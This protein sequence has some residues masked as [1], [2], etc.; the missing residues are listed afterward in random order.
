MYSPCQGL[1]GILPVYSLLEFVLILHPICFFQKVKDIAERAG[2]GE[3]GGFQ[4][5]AEIAWF[6]LCLAVESPWLAAS[7]P[8]L[9]SF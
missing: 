5:Y 3:V 8:F 1:T 4:H 7:R 6:L 2:H 9:S